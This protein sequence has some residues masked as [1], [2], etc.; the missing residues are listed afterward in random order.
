LSELRPP[1]AN[2]RG[3]RSPWRVRA[4]SAHHSL[5]GACLR[6]PTS[7][8]GTPTPAS[9]G[10][11]SRC[12]PTREPSASTRPIVWA[13]R[14]TRPSWRIGA[15]VGSWR[16]G[17]ATNLVAVSP[18][19]VAS[20]TRHARRAT[21]KT[22]RPGSASDY[23]ASRARDRLA[24]HSSRS[25]SLHRRF[26]TGRRSGRCRRSRR[27]PGSASSSDPVLPST[28]S[29]RCRRRARSPRCPR[30]SAVLPTYSA[31]C[32][33][34]FCSERTDRNCRLFCSSAAAGIADRKSTMP[35]LV[36]VVLR[37]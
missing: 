23:R 5:L 15:M 24:R 7:A 12:S 21:G 22:R 29:S 32:T 27:L 33:A 28:S 20:S 18:S 26:A 1:A 10:V 6:T 9:A 3:C 31:S 14:R 13:R 16:S 34:V 2:G 35:M 8:R 30:G 4:R 11:P 36:N 19:C 25:Q 17:R 37:T